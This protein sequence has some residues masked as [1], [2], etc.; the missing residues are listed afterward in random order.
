MPRRQWEV[1]MYLFQK[2]N[3]TR[4]IARLKKMRAAPNLMEMLIKR[5]KKKQNKKSIVYKQNKIKPKKRPKGPKRVVLK[6]RKP[7]E[8]RRGLRVKLA[9]QRRRKKQSLQRRRRSINNMGEDLAQNNDYIDI[10]SF[11]VRDKRAFEEVD[12][13]LVRKKRKVDKLSD[14]LLFDFEQNPG[15]IQGTLNTLL[16]M[17]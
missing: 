16:R 12:V 17:W 2:S 8:N 4:W 7:K 13:K 6:K 5:D 1:L 14:D 15:K 10:R 3:K 11:D 9:A